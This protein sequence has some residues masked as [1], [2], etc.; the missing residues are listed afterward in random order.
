MYLF[1]ASAETTVTVSYSCS[2]NLLLLDVSNT[3]GIIRSNYKRVESTYNSNM[4]CFWNFSSNAKLHLT[5]FRFQTQSGYDFVTV[6]DGNSS[7]SPLLGRF[8]GSSVPSPITSS[9]NQLC[10]RF[11]SN[12]GTQY[13]G[14]VARYAGIAPNLHRTDSCTEPQIYRIH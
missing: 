7:S 1:S 3:R 12:N 8:S 2:S 6:Y 13:S 9:S 14:F 4:D 10:D 5:F 11:T